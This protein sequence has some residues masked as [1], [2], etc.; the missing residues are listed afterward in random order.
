M[1]FSWPFTT[2]QRKEKIL[3]SLTGLNQEAKEQTL[4][5]FWLSTNDEESAFLSFL[6]MLESSASIPDLTSLYILTGDDKT[7]ERLKR[8]TQ[9]V[10]ESLTDGKISL[11]IISIFCGLLETFVFFDTN[12]NRIDLVVD[13]TE[14]EYK[15]LFDIRPFEDNLIS[16][17]FMFFGRKKQLWE[18]LPIEYRL[19]NIM[20]QY[21]IKAPIP[22]ARQKI[23]TFI[24]ENKKPSKLQE[25]LIEKIT[26]LY[27]KEIESSYEKTCKFLTRFAFTG[28]LDENILASLHLDALSEKKLELLKAKKK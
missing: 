7:T 6:K 25:A 17:V 24:T 9:Y 21:I 15:T 11:E 26:D 20:A 19:I 27:I 4:Q 28:A 23:E 16:A 5:K 12:E 3:Q 1:N 10:Y 8:I 18:N 2:K 22:T 14:N 13:E